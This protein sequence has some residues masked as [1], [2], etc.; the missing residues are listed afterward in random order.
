M[1]NTVKKTLKS[2]LL[3]S[4]TFF[5][6]YLA[7][8]GNDF[9]ELFIVLK[10]ANYL[11][12]IA[13]AVTG[14]M[15][16]GYFRALRWRYFLN[17]LKKDIKMDILFSSMMIGYMMNS[18]IPRAGEVYRPVMLANKEK[19]SKASA[20]GTI[21][22]ERVFDLLSLLISFG[23]C[24]I[25][26]KNKLS[27][28]F[29]QY[30]L[31]TISIYT[32]VITLSFVIIIVIIIFNLEKSEI[33]IEKITK[34]ILPEKF[35]Q[36]VHNIFISLINGFLFIRYP[37]YY[38]QI[39]LLSVILWITYVFSTY[40]TLLAFNIN[41]SMFDANLVLTMATFAMTIP[42]PANSAGIYHL[43]C[44]ATLVNVF[45]IDRESAFGFATVNHLLGLLGLI[46][47]GAFYFVKENLSI[48][49]AKQIK[50][51]EV[52]SDEIKP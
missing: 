35:H 51:T 27:A 36:K 22:V 1:N 24:M 8:R 11:Y 30:N 41:I 34:K 38:L 2:V 17:P 20:F 19:I 42:L 31:E 33:I 46:I 32:S 39:L 12:A 45:G 48:K 5:F 6:L 21:L 25:F 50:D 43:F 28:A 14:I 29:E 13:G 3:I 7:F 49:K 37:K 15:L 40:L 18:I 16:G 26:Y 47:V 44:T 52:V 9:N 10:N 23:I 4:L